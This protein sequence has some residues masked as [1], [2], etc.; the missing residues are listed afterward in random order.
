[1]VGI[2]MNSLDV[3]PINTN[4]IIKLFGIEKER[5]TMLIF[6][7]EKKKKRKNQY[8]CI[9]D[10]ILQHNMPPEHIRQ[11][12]KNWKETGQFCK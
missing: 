5:E 6:G 3:E 9:N 11:Y 8:V 1:M 7:V 12:W 2:W 10:F 4:K